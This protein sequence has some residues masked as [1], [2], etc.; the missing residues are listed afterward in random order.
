[1]EQKVNEPQLNEKTY[2]SRGMNF[3][4][5]D[6]ISLLALISPFFL[7]FLMVM[8]SII[9]S[10]IKGLIYLLGLIILFVLVFLFQ[11]TLFHAI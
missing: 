1:M 4:L 6:S 7:A 2:F 10:N 11:N 5:M 3:N 9:N 8:I